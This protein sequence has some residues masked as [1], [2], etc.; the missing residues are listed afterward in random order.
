MMILYKKKRLQSEVTK[1]PKNG[2]GIKQNITTAAQDIF[3]FCQFICPN[4]YNENNT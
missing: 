4:I 3:F 1:L 2:T